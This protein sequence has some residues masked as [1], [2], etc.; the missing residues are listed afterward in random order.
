MVTEV[1]TR[2]GE[3][4][5]LQDE[6][7]RLSESPVDPS[8]NL[9]RDD[10]GQQ[11]S[12]LICTV[13]ADATLLPRITVTDETKDCL[14]EAAQSSSSF[15]LTSAT[16]ELPEDLSQRPGSTRQ[17]ECAPNTLFEYVNNIARISM[18][19]KNDYVHSIDEWM[20]KKLSEG[21]TPGSR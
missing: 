18:E 9:H 6:V 11:A 7:Q 16:S 17:E 21:C 1:H 14:G 10:S 3:D 12:T 8:K 2:T 15:P 13:T 4:H 20:Q 19:R 5:P